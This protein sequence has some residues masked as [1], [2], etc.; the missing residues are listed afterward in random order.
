MQLIVVGSWGMPRLRTSR[1]D[2][3]QFRLVFLPFICPI[4][5]AVLSPSFR[6]CCSTYPSPPRKKMAGIEVVGLVLGVAS[7]WP[8][9]TQTWDEHSQHVPKI[10][11]LRL[12]IDSAEII[13]RCTLNDLFPGIDISLLID[14]PESWSELQLPLPTGRRVED[15]NHLEQFAQHIHQDLEEI[16]TTLIRAVSCPESSLTNYHV[17]LIK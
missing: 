12:F 13:Y 10:G 1:Q 8:I 15:L 4:E 3:R 14:T 6:T 16:N 17:Q 7:L 2:I 9:V 5:N 11:K